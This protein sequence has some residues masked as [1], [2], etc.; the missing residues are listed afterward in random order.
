LRARLRCM[1]QQHF[2]VN[3]RR[4]AAMPC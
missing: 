1:G 3:I 4:R 2:H